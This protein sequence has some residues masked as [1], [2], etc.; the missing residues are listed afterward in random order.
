MTRKL[1]PEDTD[2]IV[3]RRF[4]EETTPAGKARNREQG[5]QRYENELE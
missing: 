3:R 4:A 5:K 1:K 2:R